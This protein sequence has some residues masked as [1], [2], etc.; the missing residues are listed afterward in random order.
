[1]ISNSSLWNNRWFHIEQSVFILFQVLFSFREFRIVYKLS[2]ILI[3]YYTFIS[4]MYWFVHYVTYFTICN[5]IIFYRKNISNTFD[6][7]FLSNTFDTHLLLILKISYFQNYNAVY[8]Q[9]CNVNLF[10]H[11]SCK[12]KSCVWQLIYCL[13]LFI[14]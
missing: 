14:V 5:S 6:T 10:S 3:P 13:L 1:M 9:I 8:M 7:C 2:L 4:H 11:V 12:R